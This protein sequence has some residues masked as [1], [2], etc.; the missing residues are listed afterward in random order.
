MINNIFTVLLP[1]IREIIKKVEGFNDCY[2]TEDYLQE[3]YLAC[4]QAKKAYQRTKTGGGLQHRT[5]M[6]FPVFCQWYITKRL[7]RMADTGDVAYQI[8]TQDGEYLKTLYNGEFRKMKKKYEKDGCSFK[9]VRV[10]EDLFRN[11]DGKEIE[12]QIE[13][14]SN[15]DSA[16]EGG[17]EEER[18]YG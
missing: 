17:I 1:Q 18:M 3:A 8:Y 2:T 16:Y 6:Q 7:F 12:I 15:G 9:S 4:L 13:G 5:K 10:V 14:D 11:W